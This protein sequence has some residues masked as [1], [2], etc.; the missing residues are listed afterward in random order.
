MARARTF[1]A[2]RTDSSDRLVK[3]PKLIFPWIATALGILV[4]EMESAGVYRA[5]RDKSPMLSIRGLSDIVGFKRRD[6]WTK[7]ACLLYQQP[8]L[9]AGIFGLGQCRRATYPRGAIPVTLIIRQSKRKRVLRI[10]F[11]AAL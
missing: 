2:Q 9:P 5:I 7:C 10:Y 8:P 1:S 11:L 4:I 3:D 6:A